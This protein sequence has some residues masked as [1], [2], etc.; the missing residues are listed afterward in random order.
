MDKSTKFSG[1]HKG[2]QF[3]ISHHGV[4]DHQPDGIWC[5]Y[6]LVHE[7]QLPEEYKALFI[8]PPVFD[9]KKRLSH[10]YMG[11]ML[12]DFDWHHGITYYSKEGGA[13][14]EPVMI[15]I[16]CDY[17]H[18]WDEGSSYSEITLE[19]DVKNSIEKMLEAFPEIMVR[20]RYYGGYFKASEGEFKEGGGFVSFEEL[21][22]WSVEHPPKS[23]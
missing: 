6:I 5:Y 3:L 21:K 10:D 22:R 2:I 17:N 1:S 18:Y 4:S 12:N 16:G 14:G 11:S 13:D 23:V 15:K 9:D 7:D 20:S 19:Y 8:L